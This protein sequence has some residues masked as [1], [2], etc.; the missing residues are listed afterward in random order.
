MGIC[1]TNDDKRQLTIKSVH[2]TV[3]V[4][5]WKGWPTITVVDHLGHSQF[6]APSLNLQEAAEMDR[7]YKERGECIERMR[8]LIACSNRVSYDLREQLKEAENKAAKTEEQSVFYQKLRE[9]M[10]SEISGLEAKCAELEEKCFDLMTTVN[11]LKR[12]CDKKDK[13]KNTKKKKTS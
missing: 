9:G 7:K 4:E 6:Y 2:T 1:V 5:D 12:R 11:K 10:S 13:L 3:G 8:G